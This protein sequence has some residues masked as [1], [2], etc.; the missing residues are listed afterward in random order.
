MPSGER[1]GPRR[2]GGRRSSGAGGQDRRLP[3]ERARRTRGP[4]FT[5]V[6]VVAAAAGP[7]IEEAARNRSEPHPPGVRIPE[8]VQAAAPAS[9]AQGLPFLRGHLLQRLSGPEWFESGHLAAT[10]SHWAFGDQC[11]GP[12]RAYPRTFFRPK[13]PQDSRR[14]PTPNG[15]GPAAAPLASPGRPREDAEPRRG[16]KSGVE[17]RPA[18]RNHRLSS[19]GGQDAVEVRKRRRCSRTKP[20]ARKNRRLLRANIAGRRTGNPAT[21]REP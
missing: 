20:P 13:F 9:V 8:L 7:A 21:R 4:A 11:S 2:A 14:K 12:D 19:R 15:G 17:R 16:A 3:R 18:W 10:L 6:R 5:P 1:P